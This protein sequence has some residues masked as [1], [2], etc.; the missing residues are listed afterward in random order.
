MK[1]LNLVILQGILND[2]VLHCKKTEELCKCFEIKD[3]LKQF[4]YEKDAI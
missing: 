1:P 3:K 4:A 2:H